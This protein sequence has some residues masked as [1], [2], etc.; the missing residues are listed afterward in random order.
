MRWDN[1]FD[2]LEGQ[3]EHEL[4]AE[5]LDLRA[6]EERLRI[7]R[8]SLRDRLRALQRAESRHGDWS[9][10]V[11]LLDGSELR[12]RP[13][14][15]GRD[16]FSAD[17]VDDGTGRAP[18]VVPLSA[19]TGLLLARAQ[20]AASLVVADADE[21]DRAPGLSERLTLSFVLRDLC[22]RRA[23]VEV[24]TPSGA[25]HGTID[26]V[27]RDHLD[28]AVHERGSARRESVVSQYRV[29]PFA[30]VLVVRV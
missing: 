9:V 14:T 11:A 28:L 13:S 26:R 29:V 24:R 6:E 2:D 4:T 30:Q 25:A 12:L 15:I 22:R 18:C 17:L 16:W 3:L 27:G 7:G 19:V 10:R 5:D 23:S 8:L 21:H 20:V 1:L